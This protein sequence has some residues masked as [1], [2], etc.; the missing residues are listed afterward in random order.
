M[1][2]IDRTKEINL[3]KTARGQ[4]DGII[5]MMEDGRY[6]IDISKQVL[7]V[8]ALLKKVNLEVLEKHLHHCVSHAF[9]SGTEE[10]KAEK[11]NEILTVL[12]KYY[13]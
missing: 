4:I 5:R 11:I 10:D 1:D 3:L 2:Q 12:D 8:Q 6:C 9:E 7:S 13:K